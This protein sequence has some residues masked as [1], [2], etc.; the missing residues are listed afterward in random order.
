[1]I[2]AAGQ[3]VLVVFVVKDMLPVAE[4][5]VVQVV[6]IAAELDHLILVVHG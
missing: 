3:H 5:N 6:L 2:Q 1:V 4:I